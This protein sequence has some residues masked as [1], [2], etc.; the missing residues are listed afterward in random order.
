MSDQVPNYEVLKHLLT[1]S[2]SQADAALLDI[3]RPL[4]DRSAVD[5]LAA[6]TDD[7][8]KESEGEVVKRGLH[9][10]LDFAAHGALASGFVMQVLRIE[11]ERLGGKSDDPAPW[12]DEPP[13]SS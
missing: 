9:K 5:R 3:I 7:G 12:R 4:A 2:D 10:A 6:V 13:F 11:W 8:V 1:A